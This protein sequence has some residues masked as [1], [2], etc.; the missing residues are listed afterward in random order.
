MIEILRALPFLTAVIGIP[1]F[2]LLAA[3]TTRHFATSRRRAAFSVA[4]STMV[5][6]VAGALVFMDHG[7]VFRDPLLPFLSLDVQSSVLPLLTNLVAAALLFLAPKRD[8]RRTGVLDVMWLLVVSSVLFATQHI[9]LFVLLW[10][11]MN[12][13]VGAW[14]DRGIDGRGHRAHWILAAITTIPVLAVFGRMLYAGA[15]STALWTDAA[16]ELAPGDDIIL[17]ALVVFA[18][19]GRMG[20]FPLHVWFPVLVAQDRAPRS[21]M[22]LGPLSGAYLILRFGALF[23]EAFARD[24]PWMAVIGIVSAMF[25]ALVALGQKGQLGA[26]TY[27]VLSQ[28]GLVFMG[29]ADTNA[30]S[31]NGALV[32]WFAQGVAGTGLLVMALGVRARRGAVLLDRF[33]GLVAGAP[34]LAGAHFLFGM[35]VVGLPGT[36][37]FVAEDL[38][39]HGFVHHH[40]WLSALY[41]LVT[42]LNAV[43]YLRLFGRVF[44]GEPTTGAVGCP[45]LSVEERGAAAVLAATLIITGI[46]PY[47]AVSARSR[48]T[49]DLISM[50]C[51]SGADCEISGREFP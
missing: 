36:I 44:L 48:T 28:V 30:M 41:V 1:A 3:S 9:G 22:L 33:H 10:A 35:A 34:H 45:D 37:T 31:L 25:F 26:A 24:L 17:F 23:P 20:V 13:P 32:L 5:A 6:A 7:V 40:P 8:L 11:A 21:I 51:E 38:I 19:M 14:L 46:V 12:L 2:G 4:L 18:S 49:E 29:M 47:P 27:L 15:M 50:E 16:P 39:A 42:A 43:T